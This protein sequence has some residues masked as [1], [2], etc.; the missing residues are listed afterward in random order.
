MTLKPEEIIGALAAGIVAGV[1]LALIAKQF[2]TS[3]ITRL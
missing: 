3:G 1:V 2:P